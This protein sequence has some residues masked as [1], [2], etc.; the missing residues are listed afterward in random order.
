MAT[1]SPRLSRKQV[2]YPI[3]VLDLNEGIVGAFHVPARAVALGSEPERSHPRETKAA[4]NNQAA[5]GRW[6][7]LYLAEA[8]SLWFWRPG[9]L[10]VSPKDSGLDL[11]LRGEILGLLLATPAHCRKRRNPAL[12]R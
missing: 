8:A 7:F 2:T 5:A 9:L 12:T 4:A 6:T 11:G 1:G 3:R 10:G